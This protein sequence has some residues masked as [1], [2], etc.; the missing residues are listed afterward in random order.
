[1]PSH[2]IKNKKT[3]VLVL[4]IALAGGGLF[5]PVQLKDGYTCLFHRLF[6]ADDPVQV[7]EHDHDNRHNAGHHEDSAMLSFYLH[8]YAFLW[9]ISVVVAVLSAYSMRKIKDKL[10]LTHNE[11]QGGTN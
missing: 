2:L 10:I 7:E 5:F 4:L 3:T 8:R 1:M 6:N 11:E 9:W